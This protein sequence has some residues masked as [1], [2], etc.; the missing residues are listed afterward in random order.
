MYEWVGGVLVD[1]GA[2]HLLCNVHRWAG[3][4]TA[5]LAY[6]Q[7]AH[8]RGSNG[9]RRSSFYRP[10]EEVSIGTRYA[11]IKTN[12]ALFQRVRPTLED[13]SDF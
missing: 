6:L 2:L 3:Q 5:R 8:R 1:L 4:M 10:F 9:P 12:L 7:T 13:V 11:F